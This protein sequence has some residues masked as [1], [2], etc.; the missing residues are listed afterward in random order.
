ME[1]IQSST[2][3]NTNSYKV[4][5]ILSEFAKVLDNIGSDAK[6]SV[7]LFDA[8]GEKNEFFQTFEKTLSSP[9]IEP[10]VDMHNISKKEIFDFVFRNFAKTF[11]A[12]RDKFNFIHIGNISKSEI[13]FFIS[14]KNEEFKETLRESEFEYATGDLSEFLDVSFCFVEA[15]M[16]KDLS[17]TEKLKFDA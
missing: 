9:S 14:T 8:I 12:N 7:E 4:A 11:A 10:I 6:N 16:E 3:E 13:V 5:H 17:N 2:A 15:D 1:K